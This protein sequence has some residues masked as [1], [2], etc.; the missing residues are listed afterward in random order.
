MDLKFEFPP[1]QQEGKEW[2]NFPT[3]IERSLTSVFAPRNIL[4]VGAGIAGIACALALS[5]E[6]TPFVP[7]LQITIFERHDILST[8]GGAINLTPVAQRHLDR[9]GVLAELDKMGTEGGTDVEAIE[10]FSSR[11]GRQLGSIDFTDQN[12]NGFGGYKGRRVMRII[13]SVAM[14]TVVERTKNI[15]VAF[16]KKL[17]RG[18][19]NEDEATLYFKDGTTATGDLVLG[20]DGVHSATRTNWISPEHPSE[21]TG[22]SFLQTVI[23]AKSVK[24]PIHFRSTS[25]NISRNGSLLASY[26]D[27]EHAQIFLAAIVQFSEANLAR[28]KIE[29]GQ[30][31]VTQHRIKN[32]LYEEM[33]SRFGKS[34]VPCIREMTSKSGDWML[35]P[36]YQVRPNARWHTDRALLLGDAAHAMPPRDE[37]AAYALDDAILF[38][39]ILAKHRHEPLPVAFK[40]YEDLRRGTVNTAFKASRRMW[41][42]NRDMGFLEG[43]LKEWT[44]PFYLRNHREEREAVWEF[45][46]TQITIPMPVEG[47]SL[48]SYGKSDTS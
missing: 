15:H 46:A 45:D 13:L 29:S 27:R 26:C 17:V 1:Q 42:K 38:S 8:S 10:L 24:S 48:Y 35:Y 11:S 36:V 25:M 34:G 5:K 40:A 3:Q 23:D 33:Q 31:W 14:L 2:F 43:R 41:E 39:R 16:G 4:I 20:C 12:G 9:L 28:C 32:A 19:E 7:D 21:Y 44:L 30:D 6:L 37:S 22:I 47:G 18:E